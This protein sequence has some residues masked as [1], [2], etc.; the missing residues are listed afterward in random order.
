MKFFV[1]LFTNCGSLQIQSPSLIRNEL[2][3]EDTPAF[4]A[5]PSLGDSAPDIFVTFKDFL[6]SNKI[7]IMRKKY[8]YLLLI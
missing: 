2:I 1:L 8:I 4:A 6:R 5:G 7:R 3:L